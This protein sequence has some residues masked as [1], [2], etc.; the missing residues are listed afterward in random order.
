MIITILAFL[1]TL[2]V[3]IVIHE[4]GHYRVA[5]ACDV[6]VLRFS[7]GF[8]RVLYRRVFG[9]DRTEFVVCALPLGGYV[10]MLDEREGGVSPADVPRAFNRKTLWQRSAVVAAGPAANLLLAVLLYA[11]AHWI[12]MS[13]PKALLGAP[14]AGSVAEKGGLRSGDWVKAWSTDGN[15]WQDVRSMSDLRWQ[16]TQAAIASRPLQLL[17]TDA[18]GHGQRRATLAMDR[19][20]SRDVDGE[21]MKRVGLGAPYTEA[22]LGELKPGG[23]A[24]RAGLRKG[25]LV[26]SVDGR[27]I[28][29]GPMLREAIRASV[30]GRDA[31]AMQWQVQRGREIRSVRVQPIAV[32]DG[33]RTIARIEAYIGRPVEMVLVRYDFLEGLTAAV[34]KTWEMSALTVQMLGKML[35]GEASLKNLSG[36]VTIADYA[37]QSVQM[38]LAYYLGFLAVVSVS[39]GVLNLLPLP[40]LDGGHLMYYLFEGVT[41]KPVSDL[42][43]ERLQR[44]GI[45][46]LTMMMSIALFNDM[47]RLL[48]LH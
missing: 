32:E 27:P 5:V 39:L 18:A 10:R 36:P 46:V 28:V 48:G 21:L 8:G 15:E 3:L 33:N 41:G 6:K 43:L 25:D 16:I 1:L 31:L 22:V 29:D 45:V 37:G 19:F 12:G 38:G 20:T 42:W 7:I 17:V 14:S 30:D 40:M 13:E 34:S 9:K 11:S 23:A 4:Y 2:G 26:L 44:G 24:E 47:A 35:I